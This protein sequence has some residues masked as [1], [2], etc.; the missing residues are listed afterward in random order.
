MR[1]IPYIFALMLAAHAPAA[2]A[3]VFKC[4]GSGGKL[5]YSDR[6][7]A[8]GTSG[9]M[10]ERKKTWHEVLQERSV[11]TDAERRKQKR[12]MAEQE[13]AWNEQQ[14]FVRPQRVPV[15]RHSGNDWQ[16]RKDLDNARTSASS[17]MNNGGAWDRAAEEQ[18]KQE[19]REEQRRRAAQEPN[20]DSQGLS[21]MPVHMKSCTAQTCLNDR[22]DPY[23]RVPTNPNLMYDKDRR[24]CNKNGAWNGGGWICN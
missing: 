18:R 19:R 24:T 9:E 16:S 11:A 17:I 5:V 13:R 4:V 2:N 21:G 14:R 6:Q 12:L 23:T 1:N 8:D 10:L 22:G 20:G 15:V 7:C 3:Q